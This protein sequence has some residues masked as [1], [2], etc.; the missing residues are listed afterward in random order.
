MVTQVL[1]QEKAV[2]QVLSN[3]RKMA[4]LIA[5]WQNIEVL[6]SINKALAPLHY[7]FNHET[8][9]TP[10]QHRGLTSIK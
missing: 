3:N 10:H 2:H 9:L 8:I 5:T 7:N 4:H 6:E 1:G